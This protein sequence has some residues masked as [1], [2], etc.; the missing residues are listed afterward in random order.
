M[1]ICPQLWTQET[2]LRQASGF[3]LVLA[4]L[5]PSEAETRDLALGNTPSIPDPAAVLFSFPDDSLSDASFF[6]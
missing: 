5:S 1:L 4:V 6:V 2:G 3:A